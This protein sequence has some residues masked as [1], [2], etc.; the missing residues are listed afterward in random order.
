MTP[1][2][3][4]ETVV[5]LGKFTSRKGRLSPG[6]GMEQISD[7]LTAWM[8]RYLQLVIQ[9]VRSAAVT[10]KITLH[11]D[12][13]AGLWL[14]TISAFRADAGVSHFLTV[15]MSS[16]QMVEDVQLAVLGR[17]A[18]HFNGRMGGVVPTPREVLVAIQQIG[19]AAG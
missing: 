15:E 10:K 17:A 1:K 16:G 13:T 18:V 12:F 9:G 5:Y 11:L 7:S 8:K 6:G 14:A 4:R 19:G 3:A 2:K